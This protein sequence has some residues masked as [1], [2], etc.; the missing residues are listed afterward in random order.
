MILVHVQLNCDGPACRRK[1]DFICS[2]GQLKDGFDK[3]IDAG[4]TVR[5]NKCF[6]VECGN[7]E[8]PGDRD[9]RLINETPAERDQ[10]LLTE[11]GA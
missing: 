4:W 8:D 1:K 5:T 6:C 2:P 11:G 9:R 7:K 3:V 10:R